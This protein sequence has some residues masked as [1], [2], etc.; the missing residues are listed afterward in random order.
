M[1]DVSLTIGS[2]ISRDEQPLLFDPKPRARWSRSR[3][4]TGNAFLTT[5]RGN[6]PKLIIN[7]LIDPDGRP[8]IHRTRLLSRK[9]PR[10]KI[11]SGSTFRP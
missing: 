4:A 11:D 6:H 5:V 1:G 7:A 10:T 3:G 9:A 2:E 8:A